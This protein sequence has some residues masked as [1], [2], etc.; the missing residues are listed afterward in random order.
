MD[1]TIEID[2]KTGWGK[3]TVRGEILR[4]ELPALALA[5]WNH[6]GYSTAERAIW[7][8][9]QT[10]STM[11]LE[12]LMRLTSWIAENKRGRGAR[13][14]ALVAH[15]DSVFGTSRMFEALQSQYGWTIG[16]FRDE[17]AASDWLRRQP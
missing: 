14:V 4:E 1:Y 7:N 16:V 6:P 5:V 9:L 8:F 3:V 12:D 2:E 13:T 15:S 17:D 11:R 10:R